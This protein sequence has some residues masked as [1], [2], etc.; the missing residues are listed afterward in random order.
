MEDYK[1]MSMP[2]VT[3]WKKVDASRSEAVDPT[4][5]RQ[6]IGSLMYLVNSTPDI[7]FA[8]NSLSQFMVEPKHVH[9]IVEKHVL[10]Y[11]QG[12]IDYGLRYIQHDRMNLK[13]Y[14]DA[15]WA[16]S[17]TDIKS[18]SGCCFSLGS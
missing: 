11:L 1:P 9:R 18:T 10:R 5:Y 6:L 4:L 12:T 16:D 8:V 15:D 13:G 2:L 14:T 17:T 3:N 7:C